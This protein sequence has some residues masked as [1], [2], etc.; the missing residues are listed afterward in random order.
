M[1]NQDKFEEDL[2]M[3]SDSTNI[4]T[5]ISIKE[6]GAKINKMVSFLSNF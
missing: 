5:E 4:L 1:I 2:N 3:D 6:T